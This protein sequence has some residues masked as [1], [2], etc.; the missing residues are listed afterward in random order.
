LATT[1]QHTLDGDLLA[2]STLN[3]KQPETHAFARALAQL[4]THGTDIDWTPWFAEGPTTDLP[5]YAFQRQH[6]W[7]AAG[8]GAGDVRG[9][10]LRSLGHGLLPAAVATA[11]GGLLLTGRISVAGEQ[12]WLGDHRVLGSVLVPGAALAEWA[13][14]A[15]DEAGCG[16]VEELVLRAPL[17]LPE[18]GAVN[19]Q[20]VVRP[21][22]TDD[23]PREIEVY[24]CS[25]REDNGAG[26]VCHA[27]GTLAPQVTPPD[28]EAMDAWPPESAQRVDVDG[29]YGRAAAAGY[30]YGPA[31]Q[32]LRAVWR[33]GDD[34]VAEVELP[35]EAGRPDRFAVHPALLDA[36]LHPGILLAEPEAG[37]DGRAWLPFA[38]NGVALWATDATAVRV[39]LTPLQEGAD[40]NERG[41]RVLVADASG[42]P[43]L[44]VDSVVMRQADVAQLLPARGV[45]GQFTLDWVRWADDEPYDGPEEERDGFRWTLLGPDTFGLSAYAASRHPDVAALAAAVR[46]AADEAPSAVVACV[47]AGERPGAENDADAEA[48]ADAAL[49]VT[50]TALELLQAWLAEPSLADIPLVLTTRGA[51]TTGTDDADAPDT[52][53]AAVWGLVRSAQM[54]NPDRLVLLDLDDDGPEDAESFPDTLR[55]LLPLADSEPQLALRSGHMYVPRVVRTPADRLV[56]PD[57]GQPWRLG[58]KTAGTVEDVRVMACPEAEAPLGEGQVR[59]AVRAA[60]VNFRDVL[61][62]LGMYPDA[63]GLFAGS[64][65]AGVVTEIGP[66]VTGLAPGDRV[67]GL[68]DGA[69][70]PVAVADAR[71]L[72]RIPEGWDWRTA[73]SVPTTFLTAW[74]GLVELAGL[75]RGESVVIHAATGGVGTAAVQIARHVGAEVFATASPG[76]Q[77][78]LEAMGI[79][80]VHRA[81]S[82]DVGFEEAFRAASGG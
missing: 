61:I 22:E 5:T 71:M 42:A 43:V 40:G 56:P 53:G 55:R 21:A 7:L 10:G 72:A 60:G 31:F 45:D 70:G 82:R 37:T 36:A 4:H 8:S 54:E 30:E 24:S 50:T 13:L 17:V 79:D 35:E 38:W 39:R 41:V 52:A 33:D 62:A 1:A 57:D 74:F 80:A 11:D 44:S 73:A 19:I 27:T 18:N 23:G 29:F 77:H 66:G 51:V 12:R 26:W 25:A 16:G 28:A 9:A 76:K 69:F 48:D 15:A 46:E 3:A 14:R 32:G 58:Q 47:G 67:M 59:L 2:L 81:S 65:G 49:A 64:E 6:Y 63:D 78:V 68:F 75:R 20:V 34:L